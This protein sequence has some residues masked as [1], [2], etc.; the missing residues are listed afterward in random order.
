MRGVTEYL[1]SQ[2]TAPDLERFRL[3]LLEEFHDPLSVRQ[4]DAI[5]VGE[6]WQCLDA[7]AGG[8]SVT[9]LL[10]GRIG[11]VGTVLALDLD[12]SLLE[13]L[14]SQ[15]VEVRRHDLLRDELPLAA[16][17]LVNARLLLMHL[18]SRLEA[19]R[20]LVAAARPGG[21]VTAIDPDFTTVELMHG[22]PTW[23]RAWSSFLDALVAGG[24]DPGYG[25]RLARDM[26]TAGLVDVEASHVGSCGP[27]GSLV[28]RLLSLTIER[29][30]DRM[31]SLGAGGEQIDEARRLL[32]DPSNTFTAQTTYVAQGRRPLGG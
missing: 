21:W 17:D 20:R 11:T 24:W 6:G 18:P 26:C 1:L 25:R 27:G 23:Q 3:R 32:E 19:L 22:N 7:G 4:L 30:R 9:K 12:T 8:G 13:G 10:C 14:A 16:F 31:L 2:R 28:L 15:R 29:L 5:G